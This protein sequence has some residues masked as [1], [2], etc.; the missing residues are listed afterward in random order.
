MIR[1]A[2]REDAPALTAFL[3][4]AEAS[5]MFMLAALHRGD[6]TEPEAAPAHG[7]ALHGWISEGPQGITGFLALS[8]AGFLMPQAPD[9]DW[10]AFRPH[11]AGR[12]IAAVLGPEGQP[13][14]LLQG[15]GLD[16]VPRRRDC[17]EAGFTLNLDALILP[18]VTGCESVPL[19]AERAGLI[20]GWRAA[21]M[22][23]ISGVPAEEAQ[24]RAVADVARWIAAD[25]HRVL[26]QGGQPVA[27]SGFNARLP[28]VVQVGGVYTPPGQ[29]GRGY[30]RRAVA[31]HLAEARAAG[32]LRATLFAVSDEAAA[33]YRAIGFRPAG[34]MEQIDFV[35]AERVPPCP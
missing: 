5:S 27:L 34:R 3:G 2:R 31:L 4:R 19:T 24:P 30:A 11:L 13:H 35:T 33:A 22:I 26:L 21:Y 18:D 25:S 15:L 1:P 6:L 10:P 29:R 8:G 16:A 32:A 9:A 20:T 12:Q 7:H 17:V 23:E 28:Q 14:P